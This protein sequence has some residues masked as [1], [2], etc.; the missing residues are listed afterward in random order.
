MGFNFIKAFSSEEKYFQ[1]SGVKQANTPVIAY[2][3]LMVSF[4]RVYEFSGQ[5]QAC[6]EKKVTPIRNSRKK[7]K[8]QG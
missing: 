5:K 8:K 1:L 7:R 4:R 3:L 6:E 2:K